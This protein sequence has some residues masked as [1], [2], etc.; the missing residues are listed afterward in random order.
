VGWFRMVGKSQENDPSQI[1]VGITDCG[2]YDVVFTFVL[3]QI[4]KFPARAGWDWQPSLFST[5]TMGVVLSRYPARPMLHHQC[6]MPI[7]VRSG[8]PFMAEHRLGMKPGEEPWRYVLI[9]GFIVPRLYCMLDIQVMFHWDYPYTT[10]LDLHAGSCDAV[11]VYLGL[12][13]WFGN[14]DL[15]SRPFT[16]NALCLASGVSVT[17]RILWLC[18]SINIHFS[19]V[20]ECVNGPARL[21]TVLFFFFVPCG[22]YSTDRY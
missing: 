18:R 3:V 10:S 17:V 9:S 13:F 16:L 21:I 4:Y 7:T 19:W 5:T 2:I 12:L 6:L 22:F 20:G 11:F 14:W 1:A 15:V 8:Q